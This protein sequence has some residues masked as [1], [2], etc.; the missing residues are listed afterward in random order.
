MRKAT[1]IMLLLG[2]GSATAQGA[3]DEWR[4]AVTPYLWLPTISGGLKYD[5][6]PDGGGGDGNLGVDVGPTD[7]L[8]LLNFAALVSGSASKG[9]LLITSDLVYLSM[10]RE[11]DGRVVSVERTPLPGNLGVSSNLMMLTELWA[12]QLAPARV[13]REGL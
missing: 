12:G 9:R 13:P 7:W 4:F 1:C 6:P 8:E 2:C 11:S 10:G 5:L 3:P